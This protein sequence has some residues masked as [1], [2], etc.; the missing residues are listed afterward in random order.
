M[1]TLGRPEFA[2]PADVYWQTRMR[3]FARVS[4]RA[5]E[6]VEEANRHQRCLML[7]WDSAKASDPDWVEAVAAAQSAV[8]KARVA[9][10]QLRRM[11]SQA[12]DTL[13]IRKH[14]AEAATP[15]VIETIDSAQR[16]VSYMEAH[17]Y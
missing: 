11:I 6:A 12:R 15:Q 7:L 4:F 3:E 5:R 9:R 2:L 13:Q 17:G 10:T 1:P 14:L 16:A 8:R